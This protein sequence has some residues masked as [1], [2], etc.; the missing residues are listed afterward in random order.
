[1]KH[2]RILAE[3]LIASHRRLRAPKSRGPRRVDLSCDPLEERVTPSHLLDVVQHP[4]AA[5][6]VQ[7][8]TRHLSGATSS[9]PHTPHLRLVVQ[10]YRIL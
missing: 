8:V 5:A 7:Q 10:K 4:A 1:M 3:D 9:L 2:W 6:H